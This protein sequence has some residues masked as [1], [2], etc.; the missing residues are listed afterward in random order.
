MGEAVIHDGAVHPWPAGRAVGPA[1]KQTYTIAALNVVFADEYGKEKHLLILN[2]PEF[3]RELL[4]DLF[5]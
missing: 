5:T 4:Y 1:H 3:P 2:E